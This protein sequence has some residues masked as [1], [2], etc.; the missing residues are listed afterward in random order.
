LQIYPP[1]TT[2]QPAGSVPLGVTYNGQPV[3]GYDK[4]HYWAYYC[5]KGQGAWHTGSARTPTRAT[6]SRLHQFYNLLPLTAS[7]G[8]L[9]LPVDESVP[10][11]DWPLIAGQSGYSG[12]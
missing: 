5:C 11:R 12:Q 3:Y 9:F 8:D 4:P 1:G 7:G 2:P 10:V 6:R